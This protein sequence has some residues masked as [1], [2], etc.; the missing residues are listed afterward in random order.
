VEKTL[1]KRSKSSTVVVARSILVL[2]FVAGVSER[3]RGWRE[4]QR[5][6]ARGIWG[7]CPMRRAGPE[8]TPMR[9]GASFRRTK[10]NFL[11][12]GGTNRL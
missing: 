2:P 8:L 5:E 10:Y 11:R 12:S 3:R 1:V 4:Y 7:N 6:A 9:G